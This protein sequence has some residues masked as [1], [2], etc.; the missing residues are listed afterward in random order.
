MLTTAEN[1]L[2]TFVDQSCCANHVDCGMCPIRPFAVCGAIPENQLPRILTMVVPRTIA[3]DDTLLQER[4]PAEHVYSITQGMLKLYKLLPD[5]RRQVTGFLIPGDFI[6]CVFGGVYAYSAEAVTS[7]RLCRFKRTDF[8]GLLQEFPGVD[9]RLL[10]HACSELTAAQ[11]QMLLLGR[12][13]ARERVASM[14]V[15]F[16][17][18]FDVIEGQPMPLPMT[19]LDIADYLGL[20]TEAISRTLTSLKKEGLFRQL[21]KVSILVPEH[22]RIRAVAGD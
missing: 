1:Q 15:Q 4:D 16:L 11:A 17:D 3:A 13:T 10:R 7:T 8:L 2:S 5:G 21:D 9:E 14:L 20:T 12:K 22:D 19:R 6:G 18:R